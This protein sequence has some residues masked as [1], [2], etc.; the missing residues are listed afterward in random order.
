MNA[1]FLN[2]AG[3][4]QPFIMGC[5]GI[6]LNRIVAAAIEAH[7]D[8]N[9]VI[10]PMSIAPFEVLVLA[11]DPRDEQVMQTATEIH[12]E[13]VAAKVEVLFD[14]RDE[15]AGFKFKDADLIGIPLRIVV[16]KKSLAEGVVE[17]SHRRDDVKQNLAPEQAVEFVIQAVA[18][19]LAALEKQE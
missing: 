8:D 13:L 6:G 19:E 12:D 18:D 17:V 3:K 14:D 9:G 11:L 1:T 15:R 5:Y 16:G 7:H 10:W 2:K 4:A